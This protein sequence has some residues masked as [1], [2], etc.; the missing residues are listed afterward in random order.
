MPSFVRMPLATTVAALAH[1]I[2]HHA[3]GD[4]HAEAGWLTIDT[5]A[6]AAALIVPLWIGRYWGIVEE[7]R[8]RKEPNA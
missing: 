6:R 4:R 1:S 8:S 2:L 5:W 7:R 3:V